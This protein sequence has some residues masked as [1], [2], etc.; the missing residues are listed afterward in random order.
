MQKAS[1]GSGGGSSS[2]TSGK[3]SSTTPAVTIPGVGTISGSALAGA[4][5]SNPMGNQ[6]YLDYLEALKKL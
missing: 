6:A 5:M 3:T 2:K 4:V 1:G